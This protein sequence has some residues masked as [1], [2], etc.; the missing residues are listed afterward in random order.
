M[1][2]GVGFC[3]DKTYDLIVEKIWSPRQ[4]AA[5]VRGIVFLYTPH[6]WRRYQLTPK[7]RNMSTPL[8]TASN[9]FVKEKMCVPTPR[10]GDLGTGTLFVESLKK[11]ESDIIADTRN[12]LSLLQLSMRYLSLTVTTK[13]YDKFQPVQ[14]V[15]LG[16]WFVKDCHK[17]TCQEP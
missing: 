4:L 5:V 3:P 13:N 17:L 8:D 7:P 6:A 10:F 12:P 2:E 9:A 14:C 16:L 1:S 11:L 15:I